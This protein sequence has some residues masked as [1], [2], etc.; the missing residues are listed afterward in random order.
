MVFP[1]G[2]SNWAISSRTVSV[3]PVGSRLKGDRIVLSPEY[4][5]VPYSR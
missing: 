5:D 1:L 2:G 3:H 4:S